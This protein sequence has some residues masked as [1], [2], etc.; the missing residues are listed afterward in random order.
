[1]IPYGFL[2]LFFE[3]LMPSGFAKFEMAYLFSSL[4]VLAPDFCESGGGGESIRYSML[5]SL[6]HGSW[7]PYF[8]QVYYYL[9]SSPCLIPQT[10]VFFPL[11]CHEW[12]VPK[13]G[14]LSKNNWL[15]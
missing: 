5:C 4:L 11:R 3:F 1:M 12:T 10:H 14:G 9:T 13:I 2:F 15:A 7:I 6:N 8:T